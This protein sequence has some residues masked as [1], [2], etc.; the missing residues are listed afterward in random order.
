MLADLPHASSFWRFLKPARGHVLRKVFTAWS[1]S[2]SA[3]LTCSLPSRIKAIHASN[4]SPSSTCRLQPE[5]LMSR[6]FGGQ[7][8]R[9][10]PP[11]GFRPANDADQQFLRALYA[12]TRADEMS[13]VNWSVAQ[14]DTF[15]DT[16]FDAQ[17][18]YYREQFPSAD[19]LVIEQNGSAIGRI[20]LDRRADELR[21]IDIAL[22]P[23]ARNQGLGEALLLDLLDEGQAA[24][25]PV[26]IHVE[27]FNPAMRL[28]LRLGFKTVE[29]QGVYILHAVDRTRL[30]KRRQFAHLSA[31]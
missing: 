17:H 26:R 5:R 6:A 20:Y 9:L 23:E 29:D 11:V 7:S 13:L 14:K 21:L 3:S 8:D 10:P 24:D 19:Y 30:M 31:N 18:R 16:Q 1:A 25:L 22:I 4:S 12:S 28:Y 15:L 27:S 2:V